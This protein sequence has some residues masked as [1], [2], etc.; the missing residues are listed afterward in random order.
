MTRIGTSRRLLRTH[1]GTIRLAANISKIYKRV[2][3]C[4]GGFSVSHTRRTFLYASA[5]RCL[6][7]RALPNMSLSGYTMTALGMWHCSGTFA[8]ATHTAMERYRR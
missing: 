3:Q 8:V 1:G 7:K 4:R 5:G 2:A 6:R